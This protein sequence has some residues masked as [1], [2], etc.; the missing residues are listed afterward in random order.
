[1]CDFRI[2]T[3]EES[4]NLDILREKELSV[5]TTDFAMMQGAVVEDDEKL[6][7]ISEVMDIFI[8]MKYIFAPHCLTWTSTSEDIPSGNKT[9]TKLMNIIDLE[10]NATL[11]SSNSSLGAVRP[12][13]TFNGEVPIKN[14]FF[15]RFITFEFGE[16]PQL[17]ESK[18]SCLLYEKNFLQYGAKRTGRTFTGAAKTGKQVISFQPQVFYEYLINGKKLIRFV[19]D[20][21]SEGALLSNGM[22][23]SEGDVV[24]IK[25]MPVTWLLDLD[26][27]LAI[28]HKALFSGMKYL[29]SENSTMSGVEEFIN[30]Q[31]KKELLANQTYLQEYKKGK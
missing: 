3:L 16:Y 13:F 1:M 31:F 27:N 29:Y 2:L 24:W 20:S 17:A 10:G 14:R 28:S 19:A 26:L 15:D 5:R 7:N 6:G 25:V 9:N 11:A 22:C 12:A 21:R 30:K 23:V 18:K 8:K 4:L